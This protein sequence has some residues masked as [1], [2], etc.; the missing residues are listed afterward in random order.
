MIL[1]GFQPNCATSV[2]ARVLLRHCSRLFR[3][4]NGEGRRRNHTCGGIGAV[5]IPIV[6]A[7]TP[8]LRQPGRGS[9]KEQF[10]V[11]H[12]NLGDPHR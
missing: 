11:C 5:A 1:K 3:H 7:A 9:G 12:E 6:N 8:C 4:T 10:R 2:V